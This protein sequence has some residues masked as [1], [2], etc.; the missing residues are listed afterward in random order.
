MF[1]ISAAKVQKKS[2]PTNIF[3][4]F[5]VHSHRSAGS[6]RVEQVPV[7]SSSVPSSSGHRKQE[8]LVDVF[9]ADIAEADEAR[10]QVD[11]LMAGK[12]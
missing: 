11:D 9:T 10:Q 12:T 6:L 2:E 8:L 1:C 5:F 3:Q 7:P 4:H